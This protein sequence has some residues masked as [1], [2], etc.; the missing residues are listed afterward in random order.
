MCS[1]NF[2]F[3]DDRDD[4]IITLSIMIFYSRKVPVRESVVKFIARVRQ[5]VNKRIGLRE[6]LRILKRIGILTKNELLPP[7]TI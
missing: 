1:E 7:Q 3:V 5:Q 6:N 2:T 4:N